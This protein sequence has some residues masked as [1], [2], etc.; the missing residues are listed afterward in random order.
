MLNAGKRTIP[1]IRRKHSGT[2][3]NSAARMASS[4]DT[5]KSIGELGHMDVEEKIASLFEPDVL[6]SAQ[7][8]DNIRR[9][10]PIEP[11]KWLLVAILEDSIHCFQDNVLA[12]SGKGK[13]LFEEA[14]EWILEERR[15]WIFSFQNVSELLGLSPEYLRQGLLRWKEK[16]LADRAHPGVWEG[17]KMAG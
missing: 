3:G 7:Y 6:A 4:F 12:E 5:S 14:E 11:E 9:K 8:F 13:K 15:D 17:T 10:T 1:P 16:R 2:F